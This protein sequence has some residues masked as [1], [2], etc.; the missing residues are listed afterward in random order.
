MTMP[1]QE[2]N[3]RE[4]PTHSTMGVPMLMV[5]LMMVPVVM[6]MLVGFLCHGDWTFM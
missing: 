4:K 3:R 1:M 6:S 2:R 5:V